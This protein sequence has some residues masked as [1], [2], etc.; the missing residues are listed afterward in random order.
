[1]SPTFRRRHFNG[2]VAGSLLLAAT[3][4]LPLISIFSGFLSAGDLAWQHITEELLPGY[5][6]NTL[7]L[8]LGVSLL[9]LII[10]VGSAW[11][12]SVFD[13]PG[14]N[15]LQWALILP[16]AMPAYILGFTWAGLLDYTSPVSIFVRNTWGVETGPY[17]F[18]NILSL[19]GAIVILALSLYPYVY[20]SAYVWFSNQSATVFEAAASLGHSRLSQFWRL[21]IPMARPAMVAGVSLVLMEVLNDYGVVSYFGVDTFTTGIFTAWFSFGSKI[22]AIKLSGYLMILV[23]ALLIVE[24]MQR[25]NKRYDTLKG[26]YRPYQKTKLKGF[27]AYATSLL[28]ALPVLLGFAIPAAML[29]YWAI[30]TLP[31]V[32]DYSFLPL[33]INSFMLAAS[34]AGIVVLAT[35]LTSYTLRSFPSK[36]IQVLVRFSNMG[37]AIPGAVLAIG[38]MV[39]FLWM[40]TQLNL[41]TQNG[42]Q[43]ILTGTWLTLLFAYL[44][45]F[46]AVGFNNIESSLTKTSTSLDEAARS[47]GH[48][49]RTTLVRIIIPLIRPGVLAAGLL[50]FIDVLK[51]LPL[52]LI[53]R[54]FNFDTLA[55]RSYEYA[56]D[57]RVPEAAP[58]AL[59]IIFMGLLAVYLLSK[60]TKN[61]V[62]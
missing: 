7:L 46:M 51:E 31:L 33:I 55:I 60:I 45:R 61:P 37:Y 48:S 21:A 52:T 50:V 18:F 36:W 30:L 58:S 44:V 39:P 34:A 14:R 22:S 8:M 11:V 53:L 43:L 28:I 10:G 26:Q 32:M 1:M 62:R 20:L 4:A 25:G 49:Y 12:L 57:E 3:V 29:I 6:Y 42:R 41:L 2:W 19:P 13:F 5:L 24:R 23:F 59:I 9:V 38:I 35:I 54:P 47:L 17:L 56:T 40:D 15:I 27:R 16:I